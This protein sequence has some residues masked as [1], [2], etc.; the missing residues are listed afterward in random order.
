MRP[1][2]EFNYEQELIKL[3]LKH[4]ERKENL[5]RMNEIAISLA[6]VDFPVPVRIYVDEC[7][8][9]YVSITP[10]EDINDHNFA[11]LIATCVKHFEC[12]FVKRFSDVIGEFSWRGSIEINGSSSID[13]WI[14]NAP[15]GNCVV[16][17]VKQ[18]QEVERW[19]SDC[20]GEAS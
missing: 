4:H 3:E 15:K 7:I 17:R 11:I 19:V 16:R 13:I 10:E 8:G 9:G 6:Q 1:K 20:Q 14:N 18:T 12:K 2:I 5:A